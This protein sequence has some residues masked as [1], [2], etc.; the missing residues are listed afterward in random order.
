MI[1]YN[2]LFNRKYDQNQSPIYIFC[3]CC[4]S[5]RLQYSRVQWHS[6]RTQQ[7]WRPYQPRKLWS[8]WC[9]SQRR[10]GIYE[11]GKTTWEIKYSDRRYLYPK[12]RSR[13]RNRLRTVWKKDP[14][15]LYIQS[16]SQ[17]ITSYRMKRRYWCI[18]LWNYRWCKTDPQDLLHYSI[19]IIFYSLLIEH[20]RTVNTVR[21]IQSPITSTTESTL[22]SSLEC[23]ICYYCSKLWIHLLADK[24]EKTPN[25]IR[26]PFCHQS[27]CKFFIY[28]HPVPST[29][30]PTSCCRY[31]YRPSNYH[32]N[33]DH[34][35]TQSQTSIST[36]SSLPYTSKFRNSIS[37]HCSN[38]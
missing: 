34:P 9:R 33:N 7:I 22:W 35:S 24:T 5:T 20:E 17:T 32:P 10:R 13:T 1:L 12:S 11:D 8:R 26:Y 19:R 3:R 27:Y 37:N 36:P 30:L 4:F 14:S 15:T 18:P 23:S 28:L 21:C 25:D 6:Q 29:K 38:S 16:R 31:S 2:L